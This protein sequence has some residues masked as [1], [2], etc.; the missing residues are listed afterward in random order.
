VVAAGWEVGA[1]GLLALRRHVPLLFALFQVVQQDRH[2]MPGRV[3]QGE[4]DE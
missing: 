4:R 1:V 3:L 2:A